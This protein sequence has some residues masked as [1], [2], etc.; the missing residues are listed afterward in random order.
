MN[1]CVAEQTDTPHREDPN[2]LPQGYVF[3]SSHCLPVTPTWAPSHWALVHMG[4]RK[5]VKGEKLL[6]LTGL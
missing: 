3:L 5:H 1:K 4:L 2:G 6:R